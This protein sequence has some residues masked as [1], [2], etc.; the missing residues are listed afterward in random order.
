MDA[1][2]ARRI[3]NERFHVLG[4]HRHGQDVL[5]PADQ[6]A[7]KEPGIVFFQEST[8]APVT[9]GTND[10]AIECTV[11]PFTVQVRSRERRQAIG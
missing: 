6:I 2:S 1:P 10:H 11:S 9:N 5:H 3:G 7:P 8:H 4:Q